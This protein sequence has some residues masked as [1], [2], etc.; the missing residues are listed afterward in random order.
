MV[1]LTEMLVISDFKIRDENQPIIPNR[2]F[3][4]VE[5]FYLNYLIALEIC[6]KLKDLSRE[7][8]ASLKAN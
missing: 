7:L 6:M 2:L 8:K 1:S 4:N 3:K 5:T